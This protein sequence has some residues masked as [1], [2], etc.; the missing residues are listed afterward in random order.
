MA[1][2]ANEDDGYVSPDF[3]LPSNAGSDDEAPRE[4]FEEAAMRVLKKRKV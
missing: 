1:P 2:E 3:D 4:D